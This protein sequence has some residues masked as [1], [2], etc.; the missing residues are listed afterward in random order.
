MQ[1]SGGWKIWQPACGGDGETARALALPELSFRVEAQDTWRVFLFT[2]FAS[3]FAPAC[4]GA[5]KRR[6]SYRL[7]LLVITVQCLLALLHRANCSSRGAAL[8]TSGHTKKIILSFRGCRPC[9]I[10]CTGQLDAS[11]DQEDR[12]RHLL[13]SNIDSCDG[14]FPI[15][16]A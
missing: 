14:G 7:S 10:P 3:E 15:F 1:R 6:G 5:D 8:P 2:A 16:N 13:S 9:V 11:T 12:G 4:F